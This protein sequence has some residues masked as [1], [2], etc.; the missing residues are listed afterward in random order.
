M[1][2]CSEHCKGRH[3][4]I[5]EV[6]EPAELFNVYNVLSIMGCA[7]SANRD[8]M[9]RWSAHAACQE[10]NSDVYGMCSNA[11][12]IAVEWR[13]TGGSSVTLEGNLGSSNDIYCWIDVHPRSSCTP[14]GQ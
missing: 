13:F 5:R 7:P 12:N 11:L 10:L 14:H 8:N 2:C 4:R 1:E 9:R 3:C 6:S